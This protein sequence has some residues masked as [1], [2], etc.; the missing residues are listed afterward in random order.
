MGTA[1]GLPFAADARGG[2]A[3]LG[4]WGAIADSAVLVERAR[5]VKCPVLSA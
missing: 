4:M 5:F 1:Y 2:A 3:V